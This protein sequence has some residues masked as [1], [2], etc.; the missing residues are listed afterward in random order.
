MI[1]PRR[2]NH[3]FGTNP[4]GT[5]FALANVRPNTSI[6]TRL[7]ISLTGGMVD[8]VSRDSK[9]SHFHDVTGSSVLMFGC[10]GYKS[11]AAG[12]KNADFA[13]GVDGSDASQVW[14][15]DCVSAEGQ[16]PSLYA[17]Y[18]FTSGSGRLYERNLARGR[19]A[20]TLVGIVAGYL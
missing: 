4:V 11:R 16:A 20:E 2:V 19:K 12:T 18:A 5:V 3:S 17:L 6:V 1:V 15:V 14:L 10:T 7:V 8:S 13:I 9:G